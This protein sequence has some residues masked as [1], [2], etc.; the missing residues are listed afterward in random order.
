MLGLI[1]GGNERG[2]Y[3]VVCRSGANL[4]SGVNGEEEGRKR[5]IIVR[6]CDGELPFDATVMIVKEESEEGE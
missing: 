1:R 5:R 6:W 2:I 3:L 4:Y